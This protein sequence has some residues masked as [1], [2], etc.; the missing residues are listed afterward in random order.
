VFVYYDLK[1]PEWNYPART[2]I[3]RTTGGPVPYDPM[4]ELVLSRL[5]GGVYVPMV[6]PTHFTV[7]R[8]TGIV[9]V[10][11]AGAG[12]IYAQGGFYIKMLMPNK[13]PMT[14]KAGIYI[15]GDVQLTEPF[16]GL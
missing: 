13:I 1:S 4:P 7:N 10:T 16:G 6:S 12:T 5:S 2:G 11:A 8:D 14:R 9:T 3:A 15:I